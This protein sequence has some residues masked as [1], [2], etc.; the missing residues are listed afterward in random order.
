M[1]R[2]V[3]KRREMKSYPPTRLSV[4]CRGRDYKSEGWREGKGGLV[5]IL[6]GRSKRTM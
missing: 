3:G 1:K 2:K 5:L 4:N 6:K